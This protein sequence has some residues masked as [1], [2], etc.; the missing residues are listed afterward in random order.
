VDDQPRT[1]EDILASTRRIA[2]VGASPNPLRASHDIMGVLLEAGFEVVPVTPNADEVLGVPT[3]PSL[4]DVPQPIDLVDV[5]RRQEHLEGV[6][7]A[8]VDAGARALWLQSGLRSEEA[9]R[10]AAE[11]GMAYVE[12][13]CLGVAVRIH[14]ARPAAP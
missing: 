7:R 10:L 4:A 13:A 12:D 5:F 1:I 6:A 3:V 8:A 14:D 11:A 2:I 9:R